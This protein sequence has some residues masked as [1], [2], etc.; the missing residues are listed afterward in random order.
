MLH[1]MLR[2]LAVHESKQ[3][4]IEQRNR[5]IIER[6]DG[7]EFRNVWLTENIQLTCHKCPSLVYLFNRFSCHYSFAPFSISVFHYCIANSV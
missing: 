3:E 2:T 6:N 7:D 1:D 5:L 4:S